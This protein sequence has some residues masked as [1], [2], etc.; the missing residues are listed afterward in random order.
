MPNK[1]TNSGIAVLV[2]GAIL[3]VVG[4]ALFFG[5]MF[6]M[7]RGFNEPFVTD[8]GRPPQFG[9]PSSFGR[10]IPF[11]NAIIGVLLAGVGGYMVKVGLGMTLVGSSEGIIDWFKE[12]TEGEKAQLVCPNCQRIL[13]GNPQFC[14]H[15]GTKLE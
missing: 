11:Q 3:I 12:R 4:L 9:R 13:T 14:S 5:V 8:F 10:P 6:S 1:L 2:I 7:V 15:C